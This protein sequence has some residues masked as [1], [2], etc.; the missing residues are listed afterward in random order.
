MTPRSLAWAMGVAG[1]AALGHQGEP[2]AT[3]SSPVFLPG[4][5]E[6]EQ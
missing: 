6:E 2:S 4:L 1:D 5:P 3:V